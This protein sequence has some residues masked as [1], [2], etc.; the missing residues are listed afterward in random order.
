[1]GGTWLEWRGATKWEVL[2]LQIGAVI[3]GAMGWVHWVDT[4]PGSEPIGA[5]LWWVIAAV[6]LVGGMLLDGLRGIRNELE[7]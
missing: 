1:M 4:S 7:D 3:T 5:L 6:F 2:M